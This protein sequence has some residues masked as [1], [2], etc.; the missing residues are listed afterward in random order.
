M[1][2]PCTAEPWIYDKSSGRAE[3]EEAKLVKEER[4]RTTIK[5]NARQQNPKP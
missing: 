4:Y 5:K 1:A 2:D 3:G